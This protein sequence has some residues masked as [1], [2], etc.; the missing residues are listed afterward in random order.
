[1]RS[2]P[3]QISKPDTLYEGLSQRQGNM[4]PP[5]FSAP[6]APSPKLLDV[7]AEIMARQKYAVPTIEIYRDWIRRF[8]FFH[9]QG[10]RFRHPRELGAAEVG[11]FLDHLAIQEK[12]SLSEQAAAR[13]ALVFLYRDVIRQ[14]LGD[15]PV[16]RVRTAPD[17]AEETFGHME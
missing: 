15:I 8:I 1:M 14:P 12:C 3:R 7:V 4:N 9:Q 10:Q 6:V 17:R 11:A 5:I 2:W 16:A 13:N